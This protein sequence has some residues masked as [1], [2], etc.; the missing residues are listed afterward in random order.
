M[1]NKYSKTEKRLQKEAGEKFQNLP[2]EAKDSRQKK[3]RERYPSFAEEVKSQYHHEFNKTY[4][5]E[6]KQKLVAY[7]KN[8]YLAHEK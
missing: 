3:A 4:T 7:I 6:Q 5:E 2:E 1:P 8:Y